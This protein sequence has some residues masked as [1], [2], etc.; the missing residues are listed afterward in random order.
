MCIRDSVSWAIGDSA[1][2]S[3]L[4]VDGADLITVDTFAY[5]SGEITL[6]RIDD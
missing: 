2:A 3:Q 1:C 5:D 6:W 4:S